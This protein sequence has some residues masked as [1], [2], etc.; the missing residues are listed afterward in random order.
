MS[1][2]TLFLFPF[3]IFLLSLVFFSK[4]TRVKSQQQEVLNQ[5]AATQTNSS[6]RIFGITIDESSFA[7]PKLI[8]QIAT[9]LELIKKSNLA[10]EL[11]MVRIV[12]PVICVEENSKGE[13]VKYDTNALDIKYVNL[14]AKLKSENLARVMA[15]VMDS[16]PE[17]STRCFIGLDLNKSV[18]CYLAR[19]Q[20]LYDQLGKNVDIWEVGNEINGD[21]FGGKQPDQLQRRKIVV[22]QVDAALKWIKNEKKAK[23]AITY[24]FNGDGKDRNN[25]EDENDSML[26]WLKNDGDY[27]KDNQGNRIKFSNVDYVFISYYPDDNF[28][29]PPQKTTSSCNPTKKRKRIPIDLS[30]TDWID[31]IAVFDAYY[32][33]DTKFGLGEMGTHCKFEKCKDKNSCERREKAA[34][35]NR[36]I[37]YCPQAQVDVIKDDYIR[38]DKEIRKNLTD[39]FK[40]RFVGGYFYWFYSPDVIFKSIYGNDLEKIQAQNTRNA[41]IEAYR[42][43]WKDDFDSNVQSLLQSDEN[44][45]INSQI[46]VLQS[47]D[48]S[49]SNPYTILIVNNPSFTERNWY[50]KFKPHRDPINNL[51]DKYNASVNY[52]YANLFANL[53]EQAEKFLA[54]DSIRDKI[55]VISIWKNDLAANDENSLVQIKGQFEARQIVIINFINRLN[56]DFP[57]LNINPD[58]VF[59]VT[60]Y[61]D[62]GLQPSAYW[63]IDD[64]KKGGIL[65]TFDG[66]SYKH[67]FYSTYPGMVAIHADHRSMKALHE[68]SH[69]VSSSPNGYISDL[70]ND[71]DNDL[72]SLIIN[73]KINDKYKDVPPRE[74]GVYNNIPYFS[75]F[76]RDNDAKNTIHA[77]RINSEFP[78]LMDNYNSSPF[79]SQH[80]KLSRQFLLDRIRAKISR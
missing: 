6:E 47:G 76:Y 80:D 74:F 77:E 56:T 64:E 60:G 2:K 29:N 38:L 31:L 79:Q 70:Y 15:E 55:R 14:I 63:S 66:Q 37:G 54:D 24:Y 72:K 20:S 43:Y 1:K 25:Y 7:K 18:D 19:T 10:N 28:Y 4:D 53:P 78:A 65:F 17:I 49:K 36:S 42:N 23:A 21:W 34:K 50:G 44:A 3:L 45:Q 58:V 67:C 26:K 13:C 16:S 61:D 5:N 73:K 11:P 9:E 27:F 51:F 30:V 35:C 12:L 40:S 33:K 71:N 41:V 62:D 39:N 46:R 59:A 57:D 68:F 52:I 75:D 8:D 69:A 48:I 32:D 22:N